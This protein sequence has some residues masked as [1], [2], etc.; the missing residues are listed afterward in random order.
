LAAVLSP[1]FAQSTLSN[2]ASVTIQISGKDYF[3]VTALMNGPPSSP[4]VVPILLLYPVNPA[5]SNGTA[6]VDFLNQTP[7]RLRAADTLGAEYVPP[8]PMGRVLFGDP[9]IGDHGYSYAEIQWDREMIPFINFHEGT[10]HSI[11]T[12]ADQYLIAFHVGQLLKQP[13]LNLP[14]TLIAN[15]RLAIG[16]SASA[17]LLQAILKHS[18]LRPAFSSSFDGV[19]LG[20]VGKQDG[21]FQAPQGLPAGLG[22]ANGGTDVKT[23]V[24]MTE[25]ELQLLDGQSLRGQSSTYRSYEIAGAAHN[26]TSLIPLGQ[27]AGLPGVSLTIRQNPL[28]IGPVIRAALN[29]LR[30]WTL[31]LGTPPPSIALGNP[32]QVASHTD[33]T[34]VFSGVE[35]IRDVPREASSNN[36][37]G[38]IRLPSIVAPIGQHNGLETTVGM[39]YSATTLGQMISGTFEVFSQ[40]ELSARYATHAAYVQAV[41]S[42]ANAAH[43]SGWILASDRDAYIATA[44]ACAVGTGVALTNAQILACF[45]L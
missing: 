42:A 5:E 27:F 44:L 16:Y 15:K 4:Y 10:S 9:F 12:G 21:P 33:F 25:T 8:V 29:H 19:L 1:G 34:P 11:P 31:G 39:P 7:M 41:T 23:I 20:A 22:G 37:L 6:I 2:V 38:G 28:V 17:G 43:A 24:V 30:N 13:P 3:Q 18:V 14:G 45:D 26:P 35:H 40:Q 36:A 32:F